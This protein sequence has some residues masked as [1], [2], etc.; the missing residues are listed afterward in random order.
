MLR[1]IARNLAA[2][3]APLVL[4]GVL[5]SC[6]GNKSHIP[7]QPV[8][9]VAGPWEF[10]AIS[11]N[12]SVTGIEVALKEGQVLVNGIEQPDGVISA[13]STQIAFVSLNPT[14]SDATGFGGACPAAPVPVNNLGPGSVTAFSAPINF[15]F[16]ENGNVFNVTA[17]LAGDGKS[18]LNGTYTAQSG[19]TCTDPGGTITGTAVL[20]LTGMYAGKMCPLSLT[21]G[22]CQKSDTVNATLSE[23]S[24]SLTLTL[25]FTAGP[26]SGTNFT[27]TGPVAGN[28]FLVQGTF[29]GQVVS[30]YGYFELVSNVESLYFVNAADPCIAN[31]AVA[32]TEIGLL[33]LSQ[34]P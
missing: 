20:A 17:M 2:L 21:A 3:M 4:G 24:G 6:G 29:Q 15:T 10:I 14:T 33:P 19:N 5:I 9:N 27:M 30:Y 31:P 12:G 23:S 8:P 1:P 16:A 11:N 18:F 25:A 28:A 7:A 13:G 26:D 22:P 32:C 34:T